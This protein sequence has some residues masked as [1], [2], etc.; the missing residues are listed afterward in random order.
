MGRVDDASVA[1]AVGV[2]GE[3][4]FR[5]PWSEEVGQYRKGFATML[6]AATAEAMAGRFDSALPIFEELRRQNPSDISLANHT[7][8]VLTAAGRPAD[9]IRLLTSMTGARSDN[10][11][12]HLALASAY[13]ASGDR[14]RAD[15]AADRAIA[16]GA[17]GARAHEIKGMIAW[18]SGRRREATARFEQGLARD[19]RHV[20]MLSWIGLIA[21]EEKRPR[22]AT[23]A[24]VQVLRRDPLQPDAL[25]GLA[26]AQLAQGDRTQA[27]MALKRAEQVAPGHPRVLEARKRLDRERIR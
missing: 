25:A 15:A 18:R 10:A 17:S 9:S 12:T 22:E 21:L 13:L 27:E 7:A 11:E 1:L 14:A 5:D 24:F 4:A 6:K 2:R 26:L 19:P 23:L 16:L 8:E 20:R 3:P